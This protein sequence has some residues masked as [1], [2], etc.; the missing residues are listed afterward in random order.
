MDMRE[1]AQR[2]ARA[3]YVIDVE[4]VTSAILRRIDVGEAYL[5]PGRADARSALADPQHPT[6]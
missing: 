4:A 6:G 5:S 2:I 1:L 3:E